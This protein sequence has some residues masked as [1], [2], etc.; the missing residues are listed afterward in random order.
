M[1]QT[2]EPLYAP[3]FG[4]AGVASAIVFTAIGSAYGTAKAGQ[5][6]AAAGVMHPEGIM[7]SIIPIIMAGMLA[8]YGF[9][10][11]LTINMGIKPLSEGYTLFKGFAHMASGICVGLSGLAAGVAIGIVGD[12]G[13]RGAATQPRLFFTT[14]LMLIFAEVLALYGTTVAILI[15]LTKAG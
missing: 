13:V 4:F 14:V 9:I 3:F 5:G 6:V 12:V 10:I 2:T 1:S 7:K 11:A 8:I 15:T